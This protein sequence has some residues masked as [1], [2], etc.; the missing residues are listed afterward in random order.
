MT[1]NPCEHSQP[2]NDL[3]FYSYLIAYAVACDRI[4]NGWSQPKCPECRLYYWVM[5]KEKPC[6][7]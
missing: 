6:Q 2:M 3:D 7:S 5:P 4:R 1:P